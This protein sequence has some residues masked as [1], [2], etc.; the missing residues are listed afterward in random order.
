MIV[1]KMEPDEITSMYR[2]AKNKFKQ[3]QIL[4]EMNCVSN[5]EMAIWLEEHGQT[6]DSRYFPDRR[7][8]KSGSNI[9]APTEIPPAPKKKMPAQDHGHDGGEMIEIAV[10]HEDGT[11]E[12]HF[13]QTAKADAGKPR[14]TLVPMQILWDIAEVREFGCIKYAPD[15]WK[16]VEPERHFEAFLRHVV[17]AWDGDHM[18][19]D[20]E[21][22]LLH[23]AHAA[24]DLDFFLALME[25]RECAR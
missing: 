10:M 17:K 24:C 11:V 14:L 18:Q 9:P 8:R 20:P 1:L 21:S 12:R 6:V 5:K 16:T 13:D 2:D 3:V 25:E 7:M 19:I 23:L 4:A 22:G 15:N